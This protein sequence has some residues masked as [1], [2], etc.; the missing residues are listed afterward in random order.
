ML[1]NMALSALFPVLA[2]DVRSKAEFGA[3]TLI[4]LMLGGNS[5]DTHS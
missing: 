2:F 5:P 3:K 4:L 1:C